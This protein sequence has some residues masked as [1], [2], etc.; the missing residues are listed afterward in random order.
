[1]KNQPQAKRID[2]NCIDCSTIIFDQIDPDFYS[3][4]GREKKANDIT[5]QI[6]LHFCHDLGC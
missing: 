6:F 1:M 2:P 4:Y 3:M 5:C